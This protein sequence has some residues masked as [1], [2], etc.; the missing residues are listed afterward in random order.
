MAGLLGSF[1]PNP[2]T[3]RDKSWNW[4]G[5]TVNSGTYIGGEEEV[6]PPVPG[7]QDGTNPALPPTPRK[8]GTAEQYDAMFSQGPQIDGTNVDTIGANMTAAKKFAAD[9][10][11]DF[12]Q[13][14]YNDAM[15][16]RLK[17]NGTKYSLGATITDASQVKD[18]YAQA[19]A[20]GATD[21]QVGNKILEDAA[22]GGWT[23]QQIATALQA[24]NPNIT[25]ADVQ[26]FVTQYGKD[27]KINADGTISAATV[28]G[29]PA[30]GTPPATGST[31]AAVAPAGGGGG[32]GGV[33]TYEAAQTQVDPTKTT[34]GL[35][36]SILDED[37][38]TIRRARALSMEKMNER[39][40]AS[41]SMA[42]GAGVAAAIDAALGIAGPDAQIYANTAQTNTAAQNAQRQFNAGAQNTMGLQTQAQGYDSAKT[43]KLQA[44]DLQKMEVAS[45]NALKQITATMTAQQANDLAKMAVNQGYDLAKMSVD[46]V[47]QLG[48]MSVANGYAQE[49]LG[50]Q[51]N[52]D[53]QKMERNAALTLSQ[54]DRAQVNNLATMAKAHGYDL[55]KMSVNQINAL[56]QLRLSGQNSIAA[57]GVGASA[58]LQIAALNAD[59]NKALRLSDQDFQR[60]IYNSTQAAGIMKSLQDG[61]T[62]I[63]QNPNFTDAAAKTVMKDNLVKTTR[64]SMNVWGHASG[65]N[66]LLAMIDSVFPPAEGDKASDPSGKPI[67]W[68]NGKWV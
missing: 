39:G 10:G 57:A 55:E 65:D 66:S 1:T 5:G 35:L 24:L 20:Q 28:G 51:F 6:G 37:G 16:R 22:K 62:G 14:M 54:M 53:I 32:G 2:S 29:A 43:D 38:P 19:K 40:L 59:A 46:Q 4:S 27:Y 56:E 58:S 23:Q 68:T 49:A 45:Q 52:F 42:Q 47:N 21:Q 12:D 25:A 48:R 31:P 3:G 17:D 44:F 34:Q 64:A 50:T 13:Q 30:P 36:N 67:T 18:Q 7:T 33:S 63:D 9:N 61:L 15:G 41:S 8:Q 60:T 26:S 11:Y